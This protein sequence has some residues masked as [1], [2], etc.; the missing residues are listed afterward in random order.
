MTDAK[1]FLDKDSELS[2]QA[3]IRLKIIEAINHGVYSVGS[4]LPSSR[5][6]SD[7]LGVAR[8]TVVLAYEQLIDEGYLVS[9]QRSGIF[10]QEDVSRT[11]VGFSHSERNVSNPSLWSSRFVKTIR[12]TDTFVAPPN[13]QSYPFPFIEG[14]FDSSLYP[15][16][17]WRDAS[18]QALS[19]QHINNWAGESGGA[20][21][22]MLVEA[23][24][25]SVL[26]RRGIVVQPD[27]VLITLGTLHALNLIADLLI[28]IGTEVAVEDPGLPEFR[29]LVANRGGAIQS[30]PV[31]DSGLVVDERLDSARVVCVTPSHQTP[32]GVTMTS[33]R[34]KAIVDKANVLDQII[35]EDDYEFESNY[36]NRP[37]PA[38]KSYDDQG[39]VIYISCLSKVLSPGLRIG[40]MVADAHFIKQA[41]KLLQLQVLHT[42]LNN[43]RTA[44]LF[45]KMGHYDAFLSQLH[46]EFE[47]RWVALRRAVNYY[48]LPYVAVSPSQGGTAL[49]IK[50]PED[51]DPHFLI[52]QA[53]ANGILIEATD[54]Y[55]SKGT[56][57]E[58]YIRLGV[59]SI[60]E[61]KIKLAVE[62]LRDVLDAV[63]ENR[64]ET[65]TNF[66]GELLSGSSI[67]KLLAGRVMI[68]PIAYGDPCSI[69]IDVSGDLV[70][71]AGHA[72]EDRDVGEWWLEGD[73]WCRQWQRW[74]W[75]DV[76]KYY[77]GY[78]REKNIFKL[79]DE[80]GRLIDQGIILVP[81]TV[82]SNCS[83]DIDNW[84]Q[85]KNIS[86]STPI[87]TENV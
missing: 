44:A 8:N 42:P 29:D 56:D 47:K 71:T 25:S 70:G 72:H 28:S 78:I 64:V 82:D 4:R 73:L 53:A 22:P 87:E 10:V 32:T 39:R 69:K 40:F 58:N 33:E 85:L 79:F 75:G 2:L 6:L 51:M 15:V 19:V 41:R 18:R 54:A 14:Q 3:H 21:D 31:D 49:W 50:V 37:Q 30:I 20:D 24:C 46:H 60:E 57:A 84:T 7:Q 9:R 26:P 1:I 48:L 80:Q 59:T 74:A 81:D 86:G 77:V 38:L 83:A 23:I 52:K 67:T 45:I 35:I 66:E 61:Q 62:R 34:R 17:E 65:L 36:L 68:C 16:K 5:K 55:Y 43:Q 12:K 76:G 27:Q 63:S 13:W 11:H